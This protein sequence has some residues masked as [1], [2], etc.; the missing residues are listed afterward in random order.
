MRKLVTYDATVLFPRH[1]DATHQ[2]M[3]EI[4]RDQRSCRRTKRNI[5]S[6]KPLNQDSKA[7][8]SLRYRWIDSSSSFNLSY[9]SAPTRPPSNY[10]QAKI[11]ISHRIRSDLNQAQGLPRNPRLN[12]FRSSQEGKKLTYNTHLFRTQYHAGNGT[13][14]RIR[15]LPQPPALHQAPQATLLQ[16]N[17]TAD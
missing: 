11:N 15:P 1:H 3:V 13:G 17:H 10:G 8:R 7:R 6:S 5:T 4:R 12:F 9:K 2:L 14:P 16:P